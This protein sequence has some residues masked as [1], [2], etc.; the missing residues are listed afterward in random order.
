MTSSF[1]LGAFAGSQ[2]PVCRY[3]QRGNTPDLPEPVSRILKGIKHQ[4]IVE[5][6]DFFVEDHR[7]YLVLEYIEGLNLSRLVK[8]K[9]PRSI[10]EVVD[11]ALQIP[12]SMPG[13]VMQVL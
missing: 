11:L 8:S 2:I 13:S 12:L 9:G 7:G 1:C 3:D 6:L 10:D 4:Q 5:L